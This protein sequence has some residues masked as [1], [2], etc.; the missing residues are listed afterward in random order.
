MDLKLLGPPRSVT[1]AV[2]TQLGL[3]CFFPICLLFSMNVFASLDFP[4]TSGEGVSGYIFSTSFSCMFVSFC[5]VGDSLF[6][7]GVGVLLSV[8]DCTSMYF[9]YSTLSSSSWIDSIED[10]SEYFPCSSNSANSNS[11]DSEGSMFKSQMEDS[12]SLFIAM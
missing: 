9:K 2:H 1:E 6:F 8:G 7:D 3:V 10:S 5:L 4:G 12:L 11:I